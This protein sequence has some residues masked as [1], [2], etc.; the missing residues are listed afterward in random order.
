MRQETRNTALEPGKAEKGFSF[1]RRRE[2]DWPFQPVKS[3]WDF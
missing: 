1:S 2:H 3:V